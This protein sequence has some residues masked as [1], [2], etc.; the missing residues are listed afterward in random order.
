MATIWNLDAHDIGL[1]WHNFTT[2]YFSFFLEVEII[3]ITI[4]YI[5]FHA[6][7]GMIHFSH[8]SLEILFQKRSLKNNICFEWYQFHNKKTSNVLFWPNLLSFWPRRF[9][10]RRLRPWLRLRA[11]FLRKQIFKSWM[12]YFYFGWIEFILV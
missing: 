12:A 6:W 10:L 11:I 8:R 4:V 5:F 1:T 2:F 3:F 7:Y 9:W